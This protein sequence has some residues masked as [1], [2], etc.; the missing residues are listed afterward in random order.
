MSWETCLCVKWY[1]E[2]QT[3]MMNNLQNCFDSRDKARCERMCC[4]GSQLIDCSLHPFEALIKGLQREQHI[5]IGMDAP[6]KPSLRV[7]THLWV[8]EAGG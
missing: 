6:V 8:Q 1:V 5:Y 2:K 4:I 3:C 7:H